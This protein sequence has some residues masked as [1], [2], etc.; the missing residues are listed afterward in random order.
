MEATL[1]RIAQFLLVMGLVCTPLTGQDTVPVQPAAKPRATETIQGNGSRLLLTPSRNKLQPAA[2]IERPATNRPL[3]AAG[4]KPDVTTILEFEILTTRQQADTSAQ[5]WG[6]VFEK[7][8]HKVSI[9]SAG[10]GATAGVVERPRGSLRFVTATAFL[11]RQGN[12]EF[13]Q[14]S[15]TL[16]QSEQLGEW[17]GELVVYGAQGSPDGQPMWGLNRKQFEELYTLLAKPLPVSP[18]GM[19]VRQLLEALRRDHHIPLRLHTT[20]ATQLDAAAEVV[21]VT[22]LHEGFST[23]TGLAVALREV[24]AGFRPVRTPAGP[25]ELEVLPLDQMKTPW[26]MGW[27]PKAETPRNRIVPALFKNNPVVE[28]QDAP[29]GEVLVAL[30]AETQTPIVVDERQCLARKVDVRTVVTSYPAKRNTAWILV[31]ASTVRKAGLDYQVRQDEAGL[32]FI[33][34]APF[35][36]QAAAK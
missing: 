9:R 18:A 36:P 28:L 8:G 35:A 6:K 4:N 13:G 11:G 21:V 17:I 3:P 23:G 34:I 27:E 2:P 15:F 20:L 25:V 10:E 26:P 19:E 12:L 32:G 30:A 24:G 16:D 7:L 14:Q 29:L 33:L 5:A 1:I 22:G 31:L